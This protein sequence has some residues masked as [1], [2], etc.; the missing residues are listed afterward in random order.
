MF[1][2]TTK[3]I[4]REN[5]SYTVTRNTVIILRQCL[6]WVR[7]FSSLA[8][9]YPVAATGQVRGV[10]G[11]SGRANRMSRERVKSYCS[12]YCALYCCYCS[13]HWY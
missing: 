4:G 13:H 2:D 11:A 7:I 8:L 5:I 3:G 6:R 9:Y 1:F 10:V 12:C